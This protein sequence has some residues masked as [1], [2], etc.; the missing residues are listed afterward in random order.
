[1]PVK[2]RSQWADS[3]LTK[4]RQVLEVGSEA[5]DVL[6]H[7]QD[8][9][10]PVSLA[11]VGLRVIN[12][13]REHR[14][15]TP[16]EHFAEWRTL[17]PGRLRDQALVAA[18]VDPEAVVAE[19]P[20]MHEKRP[21]LVVELG[22]YKF[23]WAIH[24]SLKD[25]NARA[26]HCWIPAD[27]DP[28]AALQRLGRALWT[29]LDSSEGSIG[30]EIAGEEEDAG[31]Q[32]VTEGEGEALPSERGDEI[33]ERI[34]AFLDKGF[35]RSLFL[36]GEAGVG[37]SSMLRYIAGRRGGFRL[38][39]RLGRLQEVPPTALSRI[40]QML[41]PDVLIIDDLDRYVM[42]TGPYDDDKNHH[43]N[44]TPEA[45]AMLEPLE[46]FNRL[47]PLVL[48]SANFSKTITAALLRPGRFDEILTIDKLGEDLYR[49]MLPDAPAKVIKALVRD[50]V[51]VVYIGELQKRVE[52]LGYEGAAKEMKSLLERTDRVLQLNKRRVKKPKSSMV[53]KTPRQR[54]LIFAGRASEYERRAERLVKYAAQFR[55]KAERQRA[56]AEDERQKAERARASKAKE[57][58]RSVKR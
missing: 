55:E 47:V 12:S 51:P 11:A 28:D 45:N 14:A 57:K 39:C 17:D 37:K 16:E 23:G 56:K 15:R 6:V 13:V 46:V 33:Y 22:S 40:V 31:L 48:V 18:R 35:H 53:G 3:L 58:V 41:R 43:S 52:V 54:A 30:K 19:V 32:L 21:A 50:K 24:G 8:R 9:A 25:P 20:G 38:R 27:V 44:A 10:G 29:H 26:R 4:A 1:M 42:G 7:L 2:K 34:S 49:K 36:I 5:A